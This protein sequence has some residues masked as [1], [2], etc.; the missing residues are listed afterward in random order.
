MA[1]PIGWFEKA[2]EV[3]QTY[4]GWATTVGLGYWIWKTRAEHKDERKELNA[5]AKTERD[6]VVERNAERYK[7]LE[8][9]A[10]ARTDKYEELAG[11]VIEN[12]GEQTRRLDAIEKEQTELRRLVEKALEKKE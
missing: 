10:K 11:K 1:D 2:A 8:S 3:L 6:E 5:A 4:G 12:E 9:Q 7:E